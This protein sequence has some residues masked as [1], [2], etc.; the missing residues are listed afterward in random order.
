MCRSVK[1]YAAASADTR[2]AY[3]NVDDI[4]A[5]T[6]SACRV[7]TDKLRLV[8]LSV[9]VETDRPI[10]EKVYPDFVVNI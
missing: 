8:E 7:V 9:F 10:N 1:M 6:P 2:V 4:T 3:S 5:V